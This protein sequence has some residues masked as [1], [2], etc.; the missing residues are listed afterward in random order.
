LNGINLFQEKVYQ[1]VKEILGDREVTMKDCSRMVYLEQVIKETM[2]RFTI[3][4]MV[5]RNNVDTLQLS[6]E[7]FYKLYVEYLLE[8]IK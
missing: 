7:L 5:L 1:E 8:E 3:A 6:I 2:R 4:P